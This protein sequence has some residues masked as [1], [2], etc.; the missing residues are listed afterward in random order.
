MEDEAFSCSSAQSGASK[1]SQQPVAESPQGSSTTGPPRICLHRHLLFDECAPWDSVYD[2]GSSDHASEKKDMVVARTG[3]EMHHLG[4]CTPCPWR[5][6]G[7]LEGS[8][9]TFCHTCIG[10]TARE[11]R[12]EHLAEMSSKNVLQV[13]AA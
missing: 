7:C 8:K 9:C 2:A 10:A 1:T 4:K 5:W 11:T 3:C 12:K 6:K 13:L